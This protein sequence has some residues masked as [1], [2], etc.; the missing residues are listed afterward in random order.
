M[1]INATIIGA[2]GYSG[3]EL[4]KILTGHGGVHVMAITSTS[5]VGKPITDLYPN[6]LGTSDLVFSELN[7]DDAAAG[8]VV[9]LALPHGQA[10]E[11]AP[12][13]LEAGSAKVIDLSGD[14]R[15]P[16]DVYEE[17]YKKAHSA[18]S[19]ANKAV[20]GL[21]EINRDAIASADIVA[22][23][24]CFPTGVALAAA[25]LA[26]AGIIEPAIT[27]NCLTGVSGAGRTATEATHF[28]RA[29]ENA[30]AYKI[31]GVH[32]HIPEMEQTLG[33]IQVAF[34][35]VLAPFSRGIYSV[36]TASAQTGLTGESLTALY[37]DYYQGSPFVQILPP[38][39]SPQVKAVAGSNYCHIGLA[40][41]PR[42]NKVTMISAI[43]NLVKGAAGQ[44]VQNMNIMFGFDETAGL[45]MPGLY[46]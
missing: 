43:D 32:Q 1:K 13:L 36:L 45:S 22:N 28:C 34:T 11:I 19:L 3:A 18:P 9:F 38:G 42:L 5:L 12:R 41:D 23:P 8:D 6:L 14:F 37:Q 21:S 15:L 39:Q 25:P 44:A 7:I 31:G 27:A 46:P 20:Y 33:G 29:D 40:F 24:G 16:A 26:A 17:W 2:S 4:V 10:M 35:P 30:A